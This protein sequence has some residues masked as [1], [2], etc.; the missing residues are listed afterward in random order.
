MPVHDELI[1]EV[2][3]AEVADALVTINE[4]MPE[5]DLFSVPLDIET[6]VLHRWGDHYRDEGRDGLW[7]QGQWVES[8]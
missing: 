7:S 2:P 6:D 8:A 5:R 3:D 4:I 1:F